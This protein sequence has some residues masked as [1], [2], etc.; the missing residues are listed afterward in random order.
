MIH[1]SSVRNRNFL[2]QN[3]IEK[4]DYIKVDLK[5]RII[6]SGLWCDE[7]PANFFDLFVIDLKM[8]NSLVWIFSENVLHICQ[9]LS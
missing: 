8:P 1:Y 9:V 7:V 3:R 4:L 5:E 2:T 6:N